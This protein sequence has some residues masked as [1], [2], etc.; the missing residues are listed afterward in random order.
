MLSPLQVT[1]GL[2]KE[3]I[4]ELTHESKLP[5][6][7]RPPLNLYLISELVSLLGGPE[8]EESAGSGAPG[9]AILPGR[10]QGAAGHQEVSFR[11]RYQLFTLVS[12]SVS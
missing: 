10:R 11:R 9:K 3:A 2:L 5:L 8:S 6:A 4:E 1:Q 7:C 12:L